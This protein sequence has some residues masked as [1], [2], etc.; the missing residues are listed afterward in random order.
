MKRMKRI[1]VEAAVC[2]LLVGLAMAWLNPHGLAAASA[3]ALRRTSM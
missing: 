2:L 3:P 1:V